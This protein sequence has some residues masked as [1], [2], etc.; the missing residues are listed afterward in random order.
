MRELQRLGPALWG[1]AEVAVRRG[2]AR[3]ALELADEGRRASAAVEDAAYR[4]PFL[5]TGVRA[6]L[7]ADD[8]G[9]A[10]RWLEEETGALRQRDLPGAR[11]AIA[12]GE[13]LVLLAEGSTGR[14]RARLDAARTGWSTRGRTW[15]G[16]WAT[17]DLARAAARSNLRSV[18]ARLA[19]EAAAVAH[20]LPAPA[21]AEAAA[22]IG[23]SAGGRRDVVDPWAPLTAREFEVARA[24]ARGL[25]NVGIAD[26]LGISR[27]T[28]SAHV[29]HILAKLGVGRRA[30][31]AAW[32]A[33]RPVLHSA[34]HGDDREE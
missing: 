10:R 2:E 19:G 4:F 22:A 1:L 34:P 8:P 15:E 23:A 26:A 11:P 28:A 16:T 7:A 20:S 29:E 30:E 3:S 21:I 27:K 17:V 33:G 25:T 12:H 31:I 5:V 6:A 18:A 13:G 9:A 24:V 32:V 14:A